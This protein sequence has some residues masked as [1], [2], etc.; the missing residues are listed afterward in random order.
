MRLCLFCSAVLGVLFL[1][2]CVSP[3]AG[4]WTL[5]P[6]Q[7]EGA[8]SVAAMTLAGDGTFTA[9]A[10]YGDSSQVI[11]GHYAYSDGTL[12][13]ETDGTSRSYGAVVAGDELEVTH[14]DTTVKMIR[15]QPREK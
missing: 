10:K 7:P 2:G 8:V 6:D 12:T 15:M 3:L 1:T 9:S 5:A 14:E 11:S 13:F 4:T